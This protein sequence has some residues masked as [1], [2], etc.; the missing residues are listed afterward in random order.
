MIS[1]WRRELDA[2]GVHLGEDDASVAQARAALGP[3]TGDRC[4]LL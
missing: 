4:L 1:N 3:Q 2:D